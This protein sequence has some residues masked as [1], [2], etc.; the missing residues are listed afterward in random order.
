MDVE[1]QLHIFEP[2]FTTKGVGKGTG[3]GLATVYGL[4]KQNHGFIWFY[5]EAGKGSVFKIYLPRVEVE[6]D[7]ERSLQSVPVPSGGPE[8]ILLVEDEQVLRDMCGAYLEAKGYTVL[9]AGNAKEAMEI[10]RSYDRPIHL[11]ITD[12]V[13]PGL[14]GMDLA[15]SALELRPALAVILVSGHMNRPLDRAALGFSRFLQKPFGFDALDR[16]IRSLLGKSREILLIEDSSFMRGA[17]QRALTG[18]GYMVHT[19]M[20][21]EVAVRAVRQTLPDL[22]VLDLALKKISGL[23]VLRAL[24]QDAIAKSIPVVVLAILSETNSEDLLSQGAAACLEKSEKLFENDSAALIHT[25][26][27]VVGKTKASSP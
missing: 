1:T 10:C 5:S 22:V 24:K 2:F 25:V 19:A 16:T 9:K 12:V 7:L 27:R 8:T 15:K 20:D 26:A 6:S 17:M 23:E 21:G 4:V 13:M 18:A 11:L 14:S 3:L